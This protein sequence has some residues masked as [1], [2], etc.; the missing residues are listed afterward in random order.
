MNLL[1]GITGSTGSSG[2]TGASGL[3]GA[4]GVTGGSGQTGSTGLAGATGKLPWIASMNKSQLWMHYG[5]SIEVCT[6]ISTELSHILTCLQATPA[7]QATV[8]PQEPL[9]SWAPQGRQVAAG[10]QAPQAWRVPQVSSHVL[11]LGMQS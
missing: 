10:K 1:A 7:R 11:L 5:P 3:S 4:T 6:F 9:D 8:E 2:S